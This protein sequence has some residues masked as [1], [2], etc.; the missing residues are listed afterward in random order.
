VLEL[1]YAY[2]SSLSL[3]EAAQPHLEELVAQVHESSSVPVLD[4]D[5][6]VYVARFSTRRA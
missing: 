2:L 3:P 4:G 1:G 5:E 6:V